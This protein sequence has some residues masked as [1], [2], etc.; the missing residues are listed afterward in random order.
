M[1]IDGKQVTDDSIAA[2]KVKADIAGDGLTSASG[3]LSVSTSTGLEIVGDAVRIDEDGATV[4][5]TAGTW[6]HTVDT[7]QVTGTPDSGNDPVNK[8][9]SDNNANGTRWKNNADLATSV[10]DGDITLSGEQTIDG[11]LTSTSIVLAKSQSA[12]EE[13]GLYVTAAGAWA[14]TTD[15]DA[16][17]EADSAGVYV[18]SGTENGTTQWNQ[19]VSPV[20]IDTTS[21]VWVQTNGLASVTAGSGATKT[22]NTL[23][24][25][26]GN[27]ITANANDLEVTSDT[28]TGVTV[29]GLS[30]T[31]NGAGVAID[32][33]TIVHDNAGP[34]VLSVGADSI[35]TAEI[36]EAEAFAFTEATGTTETPSDNSTKLATTAYADA[37]VAA[38]TG[39]TP[40]KDNKFEASGVV[41]ADETTTG[42]TITATPSADSYVS[43]LVNGVAEEVGDAVKTAAFYYSSDGGTTPRD[44]DD[45]AAADTLYYNAVING[46]D[47]AV[48]DLISQNYN[49]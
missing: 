14:R 17:T 22:G 34:D 27:G 32:N 25:I 7:L 15:M 45:I 42:L 18:E 43:V 6:T 47:L 28:A 44:W 26:G 40:S 13:N 41:S 48:T 31:S 5:I 39:S 16:G 29:A 9:Y 11:V 12:G 33:D 30:V 24:V 46:Y 8:T 3:V 10:A 19:T 23:D 49:V 21:M 36:A 37:A 20:T 4:S 2:V 38:G 35:G 1:P